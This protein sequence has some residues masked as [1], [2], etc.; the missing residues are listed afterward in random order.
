M[1]TPL[2]ACWKANRRRQNIEEERETIKNI[3]LAVRAALCCMIVVPICHMTC[4]RSPTGVSASAKPSTK[5]DMV[6]FCRASWRS[7]VRWR[8]SVA[9]G[10]CITLPQLPRTRKSLFDRMEAQ[11]S[12]EAVGRGKTTC[13]E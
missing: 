2:L 12:Y 5:T 1:T 9:R 7:F 13:A 11:N 4:C 8:S 10:V 3:L 6:P